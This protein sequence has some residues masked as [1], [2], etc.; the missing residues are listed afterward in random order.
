[1]EIE[2]INFIL[3]S[4]LR[5]RLWKMEK[6][7]IHILST[8]DMVARLSPQEVD[9]CKKYADLIEKNFNTAFLRHLPE[10]YS[11]MTDKDMGRIIASSHV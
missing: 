5:T 7:I 10:Q 11:Q 4:Y 9:F 3:K 8:A 2:R 6:H 1:M